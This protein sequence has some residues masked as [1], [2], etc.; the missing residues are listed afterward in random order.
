MNLTIHSLSA[1][2][3]RR[4]ASIKERIDSLENELAAILGQESSRTNRVMGSHARA[5]TSASMQGRWALR[6]AK[7]PYRVVKTRKKRSAAVRARLAAVARER[8]RKAK[9]AG[10]TRL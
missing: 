3:L 4:A 2:E 7:E 1:Q 10:K 8:W 5:G 9:A 6:K